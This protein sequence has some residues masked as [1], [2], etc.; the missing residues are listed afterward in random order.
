[1]ESIAMMKRQFRSA[2]ILM[3]LSLF[4]TIPGV[5]ALAGESSQTP[6]LELNIHLCHT[7]KRQAVLRVFADGRLQ[8]SSPENDGRLVEDRI[9]REEAQ[10]LVAEVKAAVSSCDLSTTTLQS[11]LSE[12]SRQTGL[13]AEIQD[14]D[15]VALVVEMDARPLEIRCT[16]LGVL[17]QR[18][19]RAER[20]QSFSAIHDR[21]MNLTAIVQA[22]GR[23]AAEKL[24]LKASLQMTAEHPEIR[25][26]SIEELAMVRARPD[27]SRY[28]QFRR[29]ASGSESASTEEVWLTSIFETPGRETRVSVQPPES[30]IR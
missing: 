14:A 23:P 22:G 8:A 4:G 11:E 26:W 15:D 21:L 18:F 25:P 28:I 2:A 5:T 16:A 3:S 6:A 1:M 24:A 9:T 10:A 12:H 7:G 17:C 30:V 27:G 20:L 29:R 19:P 13:T